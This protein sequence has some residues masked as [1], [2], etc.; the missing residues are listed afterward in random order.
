VERTQLDL[1]IRRRRADAPFRLE[2]YRNLSG[3]NREFERELLEQDRM[4]DEANAEILRG[5]DE[6]MAPRTG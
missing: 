5:L 4:S 1:D 3:G 6:R 2:E